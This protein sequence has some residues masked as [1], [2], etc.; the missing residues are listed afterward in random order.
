[1]PRL[2]AFALAV[3][4]AL[5]A[6]PSAATPRAHADV[7]FVD[8]AV[9]VGIEDAARPGFGA[10]AALAR[11]TMTRGGVYTVG[12]RVFEPVTYTILC[13]ARGSRTVNDSGCTAWVD[14]D[15]VTTGAVFPDGATVR[16][17]VPADRRRG[18]WIEADL[19][20]TA[21]GAP[22]LPP[23]SGGYH[24]HSRDIAGVAVP[25][26]ISAGAGTYLHRQ[27]TVTGTVRTDRA[28]A[29]RVRAVAPYTALLRAHHLGTHA[30][31]GLDDIVR[32]LGEAT[33]AALPA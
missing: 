14:G 7:T 5:P 1:M 9:L 30:S 2:I 3:A 20:F 8:V 22:Y 31:D 26:G 17:R 23:A 16:G 11:Y 28:A 6:V 19:T 25:A 24:P 33:V 21:T 27:A 29:G 12:P 4:A 18:G 10:N 32:R 13:L 15:P